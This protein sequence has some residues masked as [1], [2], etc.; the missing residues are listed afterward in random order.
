MPE[1]SV[2]DIVITQP[3]AVA[4]VLDTAAD[5]TLRTDIVTQGNAFE[6]IQR[7]LKHDADGINAPVTTALVGDEGQFAGTNRPVYGALELDLPLIAGGAAP[8]SSGALGDGRTKQ[9]WKMQELGARDVLKTI[10]AYIGSQNDSFE[11]LYGKIVTWSIE[12]SRTGEV[13]GNKTYHFNEARRCQTIPGFTAQNAI[14]LLTLAAA[15]GPLSLIV[16]VNGLGA[17]NVTINPWD[18]EATIEATL[19]A[20]ADVTTAEV[21]NDVTQTAAVFHFHPATPSGPYTL[22][23]T[24][25]LTTADDVTAWQTALRLRTGYEAAVLA[26]TITAPSGGPT[27]NHATGGTATAGGGTVTGAPANLIDG[28]TTGSH[29]SLDTQTGTGRWYQ[30]DMGSPQLVNQV[31]YFQNG[32]G[33]GGIDTTGEWQGS[34]TG[35]WGGEETVLATTNIMGTAAITGGNPVNFTRAS[36]RYIRWICTSTNNV[37]AVDLFEIQLFDTAAVATG[38]EIDITIT[39]PTTSLNP[40]V[41][42]PTPTG[43][44]A[45]AGMSTTTPYSA[46]GT[47]LAEITDPA[48][49]P[50]TFAKNTGTN[51]TV[52][53]SQRGTDGSGPVIPSGGRINPTDWLLFKA[54]DD[55]DLASINMGDATDTDSPEADEHLIATAQHHTFSV[56]AMIAPAYFEDRKV[57]PAGHIDQRPNVTAMITLPKDK[58][59][60]AEEIYATE[61]DPDGCGSEPFWLRMAARCGDWEFWIDLWC[62]RDDKPA[63]PTENNIKQIQFPFTRIYHPTGSVIFTLISPA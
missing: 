63:T 30:I 28:V 58:T 22:A 18:S 19:A 14:A 17:H 54:A 7:F 53:L 24:P 29:V 55:A 9:V 8:F 6:H 42:A 56:D 1:G 25:D 52:A 48:N 50:V 3:E 20:L 16:N 5:Q 10:S 27:V 60:R 2:F 59:G 26:G 23:G 39:I 47:I 35:A 61:D 38:A 36:Y 40:A 46:T 15:T 49:T 31:K 45:V 13:G 57:F 44:N 21:T 51:W 34:L 62:A 11:L 43:T 41:A 4:G 32:G 33:D 37:V 12:S